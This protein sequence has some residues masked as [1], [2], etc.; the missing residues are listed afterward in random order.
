MSPDPRLRRFQIPLAGMVISGS[1]PNLYVELLCSELATGFPDP[2][3]VDHFAHSGHRLL[4]L[5]S[6]RPVAR[7]GVMPPPPRPEPDARREPLAGLVR[8]HCPRSAGSEHAASRISAGESTVVDRL[9][10]Q[11]NNCQE[12]ALLRLFAEGLDGFKSGLRARN[13]MT[14]TGV[15]TATATRDLADLGKKMAR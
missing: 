4:T 1:G 14:I 11:L 3:L 8:R 13:Y 5:P 12:R 10:G 6:Y 7:L 2:D 15:P 9:E